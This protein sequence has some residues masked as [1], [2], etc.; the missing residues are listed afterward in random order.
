MTF[1][2]FS[3]ETKASNDSAETF[4]TAVT[5]SNPINAK[6]L[7]LVVDMGNTVLHKRAAAELHLIKLKHQEPFKHAALF[8]KT[9]TI[10]GSHHYRLPSR[11][12]ILDLFDKDVMRQTVLEEDLEDETESDTG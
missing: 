7:K 9:L 11:Q 12:F 4:K 2:T 1:D 5:D 8:H 6:I 10:L 3:P